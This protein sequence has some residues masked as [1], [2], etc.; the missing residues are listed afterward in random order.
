MMPGDR[1]VAYLKQGHPGIGNFRGKVL[2][3][4]VCYNALPGTDSGCR[5][6]VA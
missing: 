5:V 1:V 6:D 4:D 2:T 3:D